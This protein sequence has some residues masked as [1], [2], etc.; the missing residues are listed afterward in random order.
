MTGERNNL[1]N[2]L[3][4]DGIENLELTGFHL[5]ELS[6][7]GKGLS[8]GRWVFAYEED[9]SNV[10]EEGKSNGLRDFKPTRELES[11]AARYQSKPLQ[12]EAAI[13]TTPGTDFKGTVNQAYIPFANFQKM[14][15][16]TRIGV[17][18]RSVQQEK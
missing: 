3:E 4:I 7:D 1:E 13:Y 9:L 16:P 5:M 17:R 10:D 14:G 8:N 6:E 11:I 15:R 2:N 12:I 18:Y